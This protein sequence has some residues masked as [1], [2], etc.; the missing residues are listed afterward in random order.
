MSETKKKNLVRLVAIFA[1]AM[2]VVPSIL[3]LVMQLV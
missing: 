3:M 2:F 1:A